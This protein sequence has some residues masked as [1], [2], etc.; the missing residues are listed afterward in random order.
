MKK[1][2]NTKRLHPWSF[3]CAT[4]SQKLEPVSLLRC[5]VFEPTLNDTA[6]TLKYATSLICSVFFSHIAYADK[7][8]IRYVTRLCEGGLY[9]LRKKNSCTHQSSGAVPLVILTKQRKRAGFP[10]KRVHLLFDETTVGHVLGAWPAG[11][12]LLRFFYSTFI[13]LFMRR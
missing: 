12:Y 11:K 8:D 4:R 5:N 10:A 3:S 13:L 1:E 9:F 6:H 2:R 7:T